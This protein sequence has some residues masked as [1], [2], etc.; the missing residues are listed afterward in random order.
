MVE[1]PYHAL[2][3][4]G[5]V[6]WRA[7]WS[8]SS[9]DDLHPYDGRERRFRHDDAEPEARRRGRALVGQLLGLAAVPE[10]KDLRYDLSFYSGGIGVIDRLHVAMPC[11]RAEVEVIVTRLGMLEPGVL[12]AHEDQDVREE[13]AWLLLDEEHPQRLP[14]ESVAA[15]IEEHRAELQPGPGDSLRAW[16]SPD[17]N[18]NAWTLVYE[19]DGE[20]AYV[21]Y[22]QG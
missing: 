18:V 19:V 12:L 20:L 13:I 15:F 8:M 16:L 10:A 4:C 1:L 21:A 9:A 2:E 3:S 6:A 17:S 7:V 22:D 5:R 14:A 11:T